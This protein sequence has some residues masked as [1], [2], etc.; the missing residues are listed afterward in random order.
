MIYVAR[1]YCCHK[2]NFEYIYILST[3]QIFS[4]PCNHHKINVCICKATC[5]GV[6]ETVLNRGK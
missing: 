4:I 5:W 6:C 1:G 2:I 3:T